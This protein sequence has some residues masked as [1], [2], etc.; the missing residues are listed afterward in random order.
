MQAK[1]FH[2]GW[3]MNGYRVHGWRDQWIGTHKSEGMLPDFYV[4][5]ARSLE[6][7]CFDYFILEDSSFV[8]D[9]WQGKHDF[10]LENAYAVPKFDPS[11][12]ASILTQNTSR[13]GI[14]AT[15]AITEYP[16]YLLARL[17]ST[18]D[19]VSRGRA[20]WNMVTAS[21]DRAAQ[22]YGHDA[23][24]DHDVRYDMAEEFAEL[25]VKLW[26]SWEPGSMVVDQ[27]GVFA[28]PAKVHPVDFQGKFYK[29]RGPINS[30]RSP[31]GKS[32]IVQAGG[33]AK[34][35]AFASK[36]A[37]SIIASATTVEQMKEYRD[38]VRARAEAHGRD[39]DS[40]KVLFLVSPLLGETHQAAVD[41]RQQAQAEAAA[42]P[43]TRLA[44]M[45]YATDIDFSV[46]DLDTPIKDLASQLVTNGHQSSL[47]QFVAQNR[48]RTL[49]EVAMQSSTSAGQRVELLGTPS[50][51]A[52]QMGDV[53]ATV[54]GDGFLLT[55]DVL[56]RRSISEVCDGLVPELQK[57]GLT[58]TSYSYEM[59]RDN[60][61]EF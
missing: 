32:V 37:D 29:S 4:D 25:V 11:V 1:K 6:R 60:L 20:G 56:T 43:V 7:A 48:E 21:S 17:V 31:Q 54:G 5:M 42:N 3:F 26:D 51:V 38:D 30:A 27:D 14:V 13:L 2:L 58:R 36:Y 28:D 34:G 39:P 9:A 35:R 55:Q 49:R 41:R 15:L 53:M 10:Y 23:Q 22:N 46:F 18:M 45:G 16:P 50:E 59:F 8:P 57:R 61:L 12:L 40:V 19:H 47:Q 44:G 33:S 52:D 24:P